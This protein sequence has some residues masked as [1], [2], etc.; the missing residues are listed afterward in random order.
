MAD[1]EFFSDDVCVLSAAGTAA[2]INLQNTA[3]EPDNALISRIHQR[4]ITTT[5]LDRTDFERERAQQKTVATK[6]NDKSEKSEKNDSKSEK[7]TDLPKSESKSEKTDGK[8]SA[9]R[10]EEPM[11]NG[12]QESKAKLAEIVVEHPLPHP[13]TTC[14]V[15][16]LPYSENSVP[17][18]VKIMKCAICRRGKVPDILFTTIELPDNIP[19][20]GRGCFVQATVCRPKRDLRGELNAKEISDGLPFLEYELHSLLL[21]KIKVKS[22][23][24]LFGLRVQV[25]IGER[26]LIGMATGTAVY[27]APLPVPAVP[28]VTAGNSW[29]DEQ[30][31]ADMQ[32]SLN[33]TVKKNKEFYQLKTVTVRV[34][35]SSVGL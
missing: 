17:F 13:P 4:E 6:V 18:R 19:I 23:N 33:E 31:L 25:S 28:K 29:N 11:N 20:V 5:S 1:Y 21:N 22:M 12:G 9:E 8:I 3:Q 2:V 34:N 30:K 16:H 24:A 10:V 27:L 14:S 26:L 7:G 32:K 15:C 35:F